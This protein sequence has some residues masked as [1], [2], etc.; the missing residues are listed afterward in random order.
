MSYT[1]IGS[2]TVNK[3]TLEQHQA[4]RAANALNANEVYNISDISDYVSY[5][6]R[7]G[8]VI[9]I[10]NFIFLNSAPIDF[11]GIPLNTELIRLVG[12]NGV[13]IGLRLAHESG[14]YILGA[15]ASGNRI[16]TIAT[17]TSVSQITRSVEYIQP[18]S[19]YG[20]YAKVDFIHSSVIDKI[21]SIARIN[22]TF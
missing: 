20:L 16:Q 4:L 21:D 7:V 18:N 12:S 13:S 5:A 2:V 8:R 17:G 11:T 9:P 1:E 10:G 3:L 14:S 19:G 15:Y 6:L 22:F